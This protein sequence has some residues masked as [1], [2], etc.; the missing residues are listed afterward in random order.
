ME[1]LEL[2]CYNRTPAYDA[3]VERMKKHERGLS[4]DKEGAGVNGAAASATATASPD[5][6]N[7]RQRKTANPMSRET[8]ATT[9][10]TSEGLKASTSHDTAPRP[11]N[12]TQPH[13]AKADTTISWLWEALPLEIKV[14]TGSVVLGSDATP[15]V[16]IVHYRRARGTVEI[17]EARSAC[18]LYKMSINCGLQEVNVLMRTNL[19][20][21]GALLAHG[22][23][24]YD[25][26]LQQDPA[27]AAEPPSAITGLSG[28]Q[29]LAKRFKFLYDPHFSSPPVAGLPNDRVWKGLARYRLPE[30]QGGNMHREDREYAKVTT[31]LSTRALDLSYYTDTPGVVPIYTGDVDAT[32]E[33]GNIEPPPE[34]GVDVTIHGGNV[35]YGPWADRQRDA[36]QKAFAPSIFFDTE[37]RERLKHGD[38]RVH[39]SL[40]VNFVMSEKTT[41]RIP[42]REASKDWQFDGMK[43]EIERRYGWLDVVVGAN[44]SVTYTQSQI[45]TE[46]G[47]ESMVVLHLDSLNV[48]S[49]VNLQSFVVAKAC[50][51]GAISWH[52]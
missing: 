37:P 11:S 18:D 47:Y 33:I 17:S 39:S 6:G 1:G 9:G 38:L 34:W 50:K 5:R 25:E 4:E 20:Y 30:D 35:N 10:T 15:M 3:I 49:S 29:W 48:A 51:V 40:V 16:L 2:F 32:D 52:R 27:V 42:T 14:T 46:R 19:D 26:L 22:K 23:H 7:V 31:L 13:Q 45:A 36:L 28:F 12:S 24:A 41:L 44:S 43:G 21:S 8:S